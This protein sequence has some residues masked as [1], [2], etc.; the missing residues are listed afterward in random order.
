MLVIFKGEKKD[1]H[2]TI[3]NKLLKRGEAEL[4][5]EKEV[6]KRTRK[7]ISKDE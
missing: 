5:K 6:I 4:V 3:A 1:M 7:K 2:H